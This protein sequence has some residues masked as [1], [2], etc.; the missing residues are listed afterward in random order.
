[1][2]KKRL[3]FFLLLCSILLGIFSV[4]EVLAADAT[5]CSLGTV[6]FREDF[7]GNNVSDP[8][9]TE[10]SL[11]SGLTTLI[12]QPN[13]PLA[14]SSFRDYHSADD[15]CYDIRK[16]GFERLSNG[17]HYSGCI[18]TLTTI[19]RKEMIPEDT[20]CRWIWHRAQQSSILSRWMG[21]A[22][23]P[24]CTFLCGGIQ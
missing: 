4:E 2:M 15:G 10:N 3:K 8:L 14:T 11:E 13:F 17:A 23:T 5:D 20:S 19:R 22:R 7:G 1:M 21:C 24:I 16:R 18:G 12:H 9:Y 6:L